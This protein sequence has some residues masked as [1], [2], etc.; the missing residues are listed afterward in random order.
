M[1]KSFEW[2]CS[3]F[4]R[5]VSIAIIGGISLSMA[6]H[7]AMAAAWVDMVFGKLVDYDTYIGV[8]TAD[9][10]IGGALLPFLPMRCIIVGLKTSFFF[11]LSPFSRRACNARVW[12]IT[13]RGGWNVL[14]PAVCRIPPSQALVGH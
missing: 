14:I 9:A 3:I 12:N 11:V 8:F 2:A 6:I 7:G 4:A 13:S 10:I 1:W 5:S